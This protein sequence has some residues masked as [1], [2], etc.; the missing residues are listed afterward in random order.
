MVIRSLGATL[1]KEVEMTD[2]K[3]LETERNCGCNTG[4]GCH[5]NPCACKNCNC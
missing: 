1:K 5:C 3:T 2:R 4:A